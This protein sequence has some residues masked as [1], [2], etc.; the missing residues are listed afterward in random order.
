[1]TENQN[2]QLTCNITAES[3]KCPILAKDCYEDLLSTEESVEQQISRVWIHG[4]T[5]VVLVSACATFGALILPYISKHKTAYQLTM[6]FLISLAV[7][8]LSGAAVLVLIPEGLGL[9]ECN[10]GYSQAIVCFGIWTFFLLNQL[11]KFATK[12]E[13]HGHGHN[14]VYVNENEE[15]FKVLA[16]KSE[17]TR[18]KEVREVP[19]K[20]NTGT[21]RENLKNL[22]PVGWL[23]LIGDGFHN[24]L[25]GLAMGASFKSDISKGWQITIAILAE[26]F[27]HELGDFAV[28]MR[29]G[30]TSNQAIICNLL[31]ASTCLL[32]FIVGVVFSE[33][34]EQFIFSW[35][36]GV[37]LFISLSSMLTEVEELISEMKKEFNYLLVVM[38]SSTGFIMGYV[39]VYT[40]GKV[41]FENV[42]SF[43]S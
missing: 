8:A 13:E 23:C 2:L 22:K 20:K 34:L 42:F 1:M 18:H 3:L 9:Q 40:C 4:L 16:E 15:E 11:V 14:H 38:I 33:I 30:L 37:F 6:L 24:S 27:P 10:L 36:G 35:M 41:D 28:L 26:E 25:D 29:A 39:I 12:F 32:G 19:Q 17:P 31:S 43:L 5:A 7:S 21:L